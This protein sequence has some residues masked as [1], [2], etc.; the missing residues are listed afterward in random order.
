M[1]FEV[2]PGR[3]VSAQCIAPHV[4]DPPLTRDA[5]RA[6]RPLIRAS[7][8]A[9]LSR[10][11]RE[12]MSLAALCQPAVAALSGVPV[13]GRS[14]A[15]R[16]VAPLRARLHPTKRARVLVVYAAA[17][18]RPVV[19]AA[20]NPINVLVVGGGGRE[21]ALCWRLRQSPSCAELFCTP[22]NAGIAV[23]EGVQVVSVKESDH[24]AVIDFCKEKN[25]GALL[26]PRRPR[27]APRRRARPS[28]PL[29]RDAN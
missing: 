10:P 18:G 8:R 21:H 26:P 9:P 11:T 22:G 12:K 5:T 7:S 13:A 17:A 16:G 24:A 6:E 14:R 15:A 4:I 2:L 27:S 20:A 28:L 3:H 23:E 1:G 19:A 29:R 25:I